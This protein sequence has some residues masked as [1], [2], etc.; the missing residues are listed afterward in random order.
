MAGEAEAAGIDH[1]SQRVISGVPAG[2]NPLVLLGRMAGARL[3]ARDGLVRMSG[4]GE[5]EVDGVLGAVEERAA[6][7]LGREPLPGVRV[8]PEG[9]GLSLARGSKVITT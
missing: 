4:V 6:V 2:G 1:V 8:L 5:E 3:A 7:G 9:I